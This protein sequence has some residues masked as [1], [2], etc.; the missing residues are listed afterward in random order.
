MAW[1]PKKSLALPPFWATGS[2]AAA[3][4]RER[5]CIEWA[6]DAPA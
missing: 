6:L 1:D 2:G 5:N 4:A 3:K